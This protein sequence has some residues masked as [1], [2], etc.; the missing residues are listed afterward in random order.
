MDDHKGGELVSSDSK[1]TCKDLQTMTCKTISP[2]IYSSAETLKVV[3]LCQNRNEAAV[4]RNIT[5]LIL[6]PIISFYLKDG[7]N[8]FEHLIDEVDTQWHDS[9]V[10]AGPR[11][12]PDLAVGFLSSAFTMEEN[13]KL[14]F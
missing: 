3:V 10:P 8:Q 12:K 4:T 14:T 9:W 7:G 1:M 13:Q 5:P 6:P 11:P 2:T